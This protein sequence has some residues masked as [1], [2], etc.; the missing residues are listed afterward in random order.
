MQTLYIDVYFLINFTVDF[1][2]LYF[3]SVFSRVPTSVKRLIFSSLLGA[4]FASGMIF[5]PEIPILQIL[6]AIITLLLCAYIATAAVATYA[7]T[8]AAVICRTAF[9]F[10]SVS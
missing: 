1:L 10:F 9:F 4:L 5:L 8:A 7:G 3:A 2:A 6:T